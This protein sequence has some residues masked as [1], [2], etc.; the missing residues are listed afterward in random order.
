MSNR[1]WKICV[2]GG[3]VVGLASALSIRDLNIGTE[4]VDVTVIAEQF[5]RDVTSS[6]AAGLL[7]P[8]S[9]GSPEQLPLIKKWAMST[10]DH[11]NRLNCS[12]EGRKAGTSLSFGYNLLEEPDPDYMVG[13]RE[14]FFNFQDMSER[15]LAMFPPYRYGYRFTTL[16]ANPARYLPWLTE[17]LQE[18]NVTFIKRRVERF[19]ELAEEYDVIVN[20]TGVGAAKFNDARVQPG[21]GQVTKVHAQWIKHHVVAE[22]ANGEVSY[23]LPCPDFVA[24]GGV[25]QKGNWNRDVCPDDKKQIW[26]GCCQLIPS[27]R[28]AKIIED[29]VGLR[30]LR[31]EVRLE[32]EQITTPIGKKWVVHNYGHGG[33]GVTLHWG[34]GKEAA[35]LVK[36]CLERVALQ[37]KL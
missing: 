3:G 19:E 30:P 23:I 15:E 21:R 25:V 17:K 24:L 22:K 28:D 37:S 2:I 31:D 12:E 5:G 27:L 9:V 32:S 29:R 10:W 1:K 11:I 33:A 8:Y 6:V 36:D 18:K 16:M 7:E 35:K 4:T 13:F 20:C 14:I 26:E 34:C